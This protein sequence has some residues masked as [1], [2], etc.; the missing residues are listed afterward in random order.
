MAKHK[1]NQVREAIFRTLGA[2]GERAQEITF[3][4]RRLYAAD[5]RLGR[6]PRSRDEAEHH[7]A[8]FS[9]APPGT[10]ADILF[11]DYEA[12]ASLAA[13]M[14]LEHGLPQATVIRLLRRLRPQLERIHKENLA[15]D[16]NQLFDE[17]A[18]LAQAKPGMIAF[19]STEPV[20][21]AFARL[22]GSSVDE[23]DHGPSVCVDPT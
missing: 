15:K 20:I 12:F 16:P 17:K 6:R 11:T 2:E 8:F 19:E 9:D 5:R 3:R 21:L 10:G 14:L 4:L 1:S 23:E 22:T 7:Y 13:V 18:L